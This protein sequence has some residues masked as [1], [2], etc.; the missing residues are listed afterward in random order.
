[1]WDIYEK[2][3]LSKQLKKAPKDIIKR[4]ELWK[5]IVELEGPKGL[6]LIKGFRDEFLK[7]ELKGYR[8]SR[9]SKQWRIIYQAN[10]KICE[11]YII[12]VNPHDYRKR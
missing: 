11:V 8:S 7:G 4:Y 1:M 5:R 2:K 10:N 12:E 9:L 3:T 6:Q